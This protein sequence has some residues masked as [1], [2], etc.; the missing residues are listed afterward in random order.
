MCSYQTTIEN[1]HNEAYQTRLVF[2]NPN[3]KN[4]QR[5]KMEGN[6]Y[7]LSLPTT[8]LDLMIHTESF[9]QSAQQALAR[10]FAE[11]Y[12]Y[13]QSLLRPVKETLRMFLVHPGGTR[14]I[15]DNGRNLRVLSVVNGT[16]TEVRIQSQ[17]ELC[18]IS[19]LYTGSQRRRFDDF[20]G[21][22]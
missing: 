3:I 21:W 5:R 9:A 11:N 8:I 18:T 1:P 12:E 17:N 14:W 19:R 4:P 15:V 6:F 2:Y 20:M 16:L 10:R 7:A 22:R 13:A